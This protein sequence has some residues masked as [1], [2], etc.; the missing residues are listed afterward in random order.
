MAKFKK[1]SCNK[2]CS[3]LRATKGKTCNRKAI[4]RAIKAGSSVAAAVGKHCGKR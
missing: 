4:L 2:F 3:A 1:G